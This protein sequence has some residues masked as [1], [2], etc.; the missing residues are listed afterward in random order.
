MKYSFVIKQNKELKDSSVRVKLVEKS[1]RFLSIITFIG[2]IYAMFDF[3]IRI[4]PTNEMKK[5][6]DTLFSGLFA[7]GVLLPFIGIC[8][9]VLFVDSSY[10]LGHLTTKDSKEKHCKWIV[11]SYRNIMIS[12]VF[13]LISWILKTTYISINQFSIPLLWTF[14]IPIALSISLVLVLVLG[15]VKA[16]V[17][18]ISFKELRKIG[19]EKRKKDMEE[20]RKEDLEEKKKKKEKKRRERLKKQKEERESARISS[21]RGIVLP[22]RAPS[23]VERLNKLRKVMQRTK[24]MRLTDLRSLLEFKDKPSLMN[25]LYSLS[26]NWKFTI[27]GDFITFETTDDDKKETKTEKTEKIKEQKRKLQCL[28]CEAILVEVE[29]E[30]PIVCLNCGKKAPYCEVCKNII[31]EGEKVVQT[32]PCNHIFHKN[33]ILEWIKVKG[34]C[35]ICKEQINEESLRPF[36]PE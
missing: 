8:F 2:G 28:Y 24:E 7:F 3:F 22:S 10:K 31:V 35:P 11:I 13:Y 23:R 30:G 18:G 20:K 32:K 36:I 1:L 9:V 15:L 6:D 5:I 16:K 21:T 12:I 4:Y 26:D 34:T 27:K 25:W 19:L 14:L 33:H 17:F 29:D